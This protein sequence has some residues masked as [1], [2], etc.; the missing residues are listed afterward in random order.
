MADYNTRRISKIEMKAVH[1]QLQQ[2]KD[3]KEYNEY[4]QHKASQYIDWTIQD[5]EHTQD[6]DEFQKLFLEKFPILKD[7]EK[8]EAKHKDNEIKK[9]KDINSELFE[10]QKK[11]KKNKDITQRIT[12]LKKKK[13]E[14][15]TE[16]TKIDNFNI[17][18][19]RYNKFEYS[20]LVNVCKFRYKFENQ[21][22]I[23]CNH[24]QGVYLYSSI[25]NIDSCKDNREYYNYVKNEKLTQEIKKVFLES[26]QF[27][28]IKK[29]VFDKQKDEKATSNPTHINL[30]LH[31]RHIDLDKEKSQ[32]ISHTN[33]WDLNEEDDW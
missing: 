16:M 15:Q 12:E 27:D 10:L 17:T 9:L 7:F 6:D 18:I 29:I 1:Q 21:Y 19:K 32:T 26:K 5:E 33:E 24:L 25:L 3:L 22:S 31:F 4:L 30:I 23:K 11:S 2:Y 20:F 14:L 8:M 28:K 13:E